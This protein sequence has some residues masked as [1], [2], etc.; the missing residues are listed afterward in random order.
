MDLPSLDDAASRHFTYRDLC[1]CSDSWRRLRPENRPQAIETYGAIAALCREVLDPVVDRFGPVEL[2]YGFASAALA[3]AVRSRIAPRLDQHAGHERRKDGE[4]ICARLGQAADLRIR[5][6]SS[7]EVAHF[8][9]E[10]TAFDRLYV[11]GEDRPLHVSVGPERS[12]LVY[13]LAD[14]GVRRM[15]RRIDPGTLS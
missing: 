13:R 12:G 7:L 11:Y 6:Q 15:P 4:L 3:R 5:G 1:E 9:A 10:T 14:S 8:I 2:T